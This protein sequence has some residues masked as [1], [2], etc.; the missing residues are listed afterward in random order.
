MTRRTVWSLAFG[1]VI[2]SM[3][4]AQGPATGDEEAAFRAARAQT[5]LPLRIAALSSFLTQYP[6]STRRVLA[7]D[8]LFTTYLASFPD[9]VLEIHKLAAS[10][11]ASAEPGIDRWLEQA[12]VA[13]LLAGAG[14]HGT[15]LAAAHDWAAEVVN[16]MMAIAYRAQLVRMQARY[17]LPA[18][19]AAQIRKQFARD[20]ATSLAALAHVQLQQGQL[21]QA[22]TVLDEAY[23]LDPLSV[24]VNW[25]RADLALALGESPRALTAML[26]ANALGPLPEVERSRELALFRDLRHQDE[27]AMEAQIDATYRSLFPPIFTL[28]KRQL[29]A[30]GHPVLLELFTGSD[31]APCAGPDLALDSVLGSYTRND[32]IG[33]VFDEHVPL[34]DPLASPDSL[35]RASFY[36]VESTPTAFLDGR[37]LDV[38]GGSRDDVE[39]IVVAMGEE[40]EQQALLASGLKLD[41]AIQTTP[42]GTLQVQLLL[43]HHAVPPSAALE[44]T[45]NTGLQAL[46]HAEVFVALLQD[47]LRYTGK[48]GIRFHRMVVRALQSQPA[49]TLLS[50]APA[51]PLTFD[52]HAIE[53]AQTTYLTD[54]EHSNDRFGMFQ[55]AT[56]R[57]PI[58]AAH[59]AVVAWVQ[60]TRTRQVLQSTFALAPSP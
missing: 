12:H 41:A 10:R 31:C 55:F 50:S 34:P 3:C 18:L 23:R 32:L 42:T 28:P 43:A 58:D 26:R 30:G 56:T 20:R 51:S 57:V 8:A 9:R 7:Q 11:I 1:V 17:K 60:D 33:L 29:P 16:S 19:S 24:E 45:G 59:L 13:D 47:D 36:G 38:L 48:N 37:P 53:Q 39:N 49:L 15:D 27:A 5:E 2:A 52:P 44:T 14:A 40:I 22:R 21:D 35:A 25:L 54:F 46:Q 6:Q 4:P